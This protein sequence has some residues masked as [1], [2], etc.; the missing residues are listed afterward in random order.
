MAVYRVQARVGV[1]SI[2]VFYSVVLIKL[3]KKSKWRRV[4][5]LQVFAFIL[6]S[7]RSRNIGTDAPFPFILNYRLVSRVLLDNLILNTSS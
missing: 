7:D 5:A 6:I 1:V 4:F 2:K 3:G